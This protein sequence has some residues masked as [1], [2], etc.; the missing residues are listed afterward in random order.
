MGSDVAFVHRSKTASPARNEKLLFGSRGLP[1]NLETSLGI[2]A[3]YVLS[4]SG[5]VERLRCA[6]ESLGPARWY[7]KSHHA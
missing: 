6:K 2:I 7:D 3:M 5:G 1:K 4:E